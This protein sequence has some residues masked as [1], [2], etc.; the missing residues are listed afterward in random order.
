VTLVD[1]TSAEGLRSSYPMGLQSYRLTLGT[2]GKAELGFIPV[3]WASIPLDFGGPLDV[4]VQAHQL[5][6]TVALP[7]ASAT[8]AV[9]TLRVRADGDTQDIALTGQGVQCTSA[10]PIC[11]TASDY[12]FPLDPTKHYVVTGILLNANPGSASTETVMR[13]LGLSADTGSPS[14]RYAFEVPPLPRGPFQGSLNVDAASGEALQ[15]KMAVYPFA[16]EDLV[17]TP[18]GNLAVAPSATATASSA[19]CGSGWCS[20]PEGPIT[21]GGNQW[22]SARY[23]SLSAYPD[24][25]TTPITWTLQLPQVTSVDV[26]LIRPVNQGAPFELQISTDQT[27]WTPVFRADGSSADW[28]DVAGRFSDLTGT[29]QN[30]AR[31]IRVVFQKPTHAD[32]SGNFGVGIGAFKLYESV[33]RLANGLLPPFNSDGLHAS[34][35]RTLTVSVAAGH[36]RVPLPV[37]ALGPGQYLLQAEIWKAGTRLAS[38]A[39][40]FAILGEAPA[41]K[42]PFFG[43]NNEFFDSMDVFERSDYATGRL[44]VNWD[45]LVD[46]NGQPALSNWPW[47][48]NEMRNMQAR[49]VAVHVVFS[50]TAAFYSSKTSGTLSPSKFPPRDLV[51]FDAA[52]NNINYRQ[53]AFYKFVKTFVAQYASIISSVEIGNEDDINQCVAWQNWTGSFAGYQY[54]CASGSTTPTLLTFQQGSLTNRSGEYMELL[55][56]GYLATKDAAPSIPVAHAGLAYDDLNVLQAM[57]NYIYFDGATGAQFFDV[58][59]LHNYWAVSAPE[60]ATISSNTGGTGTGIPFEQLLGQVTQF[61]QGLSKPA[62]YSEFGYDDTYS[63]WVNGALVGPISRREQAVLTTRALVLFKKH[64]IQKAFSFEAEDLFSGSYFGGMGLIDTAGRGKELFSAYQH[65]AHVL[66]R[67]SY[68]STVDK[69]THRAELFRGT[70]GQLRALLYKKDVTGAD[71]VAISIADFGAPSG[72]LIQKIDPLLSAQPSYPNTPGVQLEV[73]YTDP[74]FV[75][76]GASCGI[77]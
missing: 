64:G 57:K 41:V 51:T 55:R 71:S 26:F 19:L 33:S 18:R 2:S 11:S 22:I 27:T 35:V 53:T 4:P 14:T 75:D 8:V 1:F 40:A 7:Q 15:I 38:T 49:G 20:L 47:Y 39:S 21:A 62:W 46:A 72:T 10:W 58:V 52:T 45:S 63:T 68:V 36:T 28:S 32:A 59:N 30:S 6:L 69:N 56:A 42:D 73:P 23:A 70:N 60:T 50:G 31:W 74:V 34:N 9:P 77:P 5:V 61:A 37:E 24:P 17:A 48:D 13:F 43:I 16:H 29:T 25:A 66:A 54:S 12:A 3:T 65:T 67:F 76:V 44:F